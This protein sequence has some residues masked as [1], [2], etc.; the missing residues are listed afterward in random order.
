[1]SYPVKDVTYGGC[2]TIQ[3][4][5]AVFSVTSEPPLIFP[6]RAQRLFKRRTCCRLSVTVGVVDVV[7]QRCSV[8]PT[9]LTEASQVLRAVRHLGLNFVVALV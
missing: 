9:L 1:M 8:V 4:R 2:V 3:P 6:G 7:E 5:R